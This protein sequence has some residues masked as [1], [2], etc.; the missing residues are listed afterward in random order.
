MDNT[1]LAAEVKSSQGNYR[2]VVGNS[3]LEKIPS[4]I[5]NFTNTK[6]IFIIADKVLF[7]LQ[8]LNISEILE[9]NGYITNVLTV[10]FSE[11]NKNLD[12]GSHFS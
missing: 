11:A 10:D 2:I 3:I 8:V 6:N 9:R 12:T 4:E 1:D 7:P 5:K